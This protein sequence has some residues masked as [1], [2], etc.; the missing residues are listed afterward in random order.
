MPPI[1]KPNI[2]SKRTCFSSDGLDLIKE[3]AA[4]LKCRLLL[5]VTA[6]DNY[7]QNTLCGCHI[8]TS[9]KVIQAFLFVVIFYFFYLSTII[10]KCEIF[11]ILGRF[12]KCEIFRILGRFPNCEIFRFVSFRFAVW[13]KPNKSLIF[14]VLRLISNKTISKNLKRQQEIKGLYQ[15]AKR[16]E[17]K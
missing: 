6:I 17:T 16:N 11:C 2:E 7:N 3:L 10:P 14:L 12:P 1:S 9:K 8:L 5:V 4:D 13:Y 15:T